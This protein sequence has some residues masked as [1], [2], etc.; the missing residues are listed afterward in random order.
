M[1]QLPVTSTVAAVDTDPPAAEGTAEQQIKYEDASQA[2][3]LSQ[4]TLVWLRFRQHPMAL[5]GGGVLLCWI[6]VALIGPV[7]MVENP[8]NVLSYSAANA[9]L[10]PTLRNWNFIFG[11]DTFGHSILSQIVW[12]ARVSLTV[13]LVSSLTTTTIGCLVGATAGYVGGRVDA[14][15]MRVTDIFL[16]LPVFPLLLIAVALFGQGSAALIIG[17][18]TVLGW[19]GTARLVRSAYLSLRGEDFVEAARAA[20][21]PTPRIIIRHLLPCA[22]RPVIVSATLAVSSFML[23]ET[24][25]DFLGVGIPYPT[26][27]WGNILTGAQDAVSTGNW[28]WAVFPG[29]ALLSTVLSVN[30][31][32]DGLGDAL[33]VRWR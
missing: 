21:V 12:G 33:D 17:I 27:S 10:A 24:A 31:L 7:L 5:A 23:L 13:G 3:Q 16:T 32:G 9:S 2:R 22:L 26:A 6:V 1:H 18:F 19:P 15:L 14:S 25:A 29:V 8:Y 11:T 20:G 28:W 30:F 4:G